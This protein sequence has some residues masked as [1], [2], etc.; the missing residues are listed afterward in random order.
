MT[1]RAKQIMMELEA[2]SEEDRASIAH[3]L[4][5]SLGPPPR[6]ASE[7]ENAEE[8]FEE[9]L[10]RRFAEMKSGQVASE[11]LREVISRLRDGRS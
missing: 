7:N 6:F 2:F 9:M 10:Q 4:L 5:Q 8:T 3:S 1:P 11:S